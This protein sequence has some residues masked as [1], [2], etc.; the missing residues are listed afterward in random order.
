MSEKKSSF[1]ALAKTALSTQE[2]LMKVK[3][4]KHT[5]FIG[6]PREIA[7]QENRISLTPDAVALLVNRGHDV[8]VEAKAGEG[9]KF[10]DKQY[11]EA[12]A[13]I[14]Y[15]TQE[16]YKAD[17]ILKIEPPTTD[18]LEYFRPGQTLISALQLGHTDQDY[19]NM[20]LKKRV[21]ALA[22]EFIEDKVGGMPIIRA[23]SEIAG[24]A[25]VSIAAQFLSNTDKGKGIILGGITGVPP[26]R[27]VIIGAGTVAENAARAALSMGAEVRVFDNHLYK[28]RRLK[29]LLGQQIYTSTIDTYTL[30]Q[31]LKTADVVIGALRAEKGRVRHVVSEDMVQNMKPDSL[32][33]DLSIDQGGCIATS[34]ITNHNKPTFKKYDVIHYCVPNISSRVAHTATTALSNIFTPTILRASEE[35]GVEEMIFLHKWFMKGVYTYKGHLVNE[36]VARKF[37]MKHKNI[38]LV[39]AVRM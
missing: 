8:W 5:F 19:I 16:V 4:S 15:S 30:T 32:I 25:S 9:S 29:H 37:K 1:A 22:Y 35:G 17:I 6:L 7:F 21:T 18:E 31:A 39:L 20:L 36:S 27:I 14:V 2:K 34:E 10:S 26:T 28:L 38:E 33:I 23:L 12:G 3:A 13:K 11:S 24:V